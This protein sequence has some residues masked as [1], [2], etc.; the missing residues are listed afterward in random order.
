MLRLS[1]NAPVTVDLGGGASVTLA[2][3][4]PRILAAGRQASRQALM[5]NA[6]LSGSLAMVAFSEGVLCEAITGW[7]GIGDET[8]EELAC[9]PE[10]VALALCDVAFFDRLDA[11]YVIPMIERESEK[12]ASAA[13]SDGTSE[14]ATAG[15]TTAGSAAATAKAGRKTRAKTGNSAKSSPKKAPRPQAAKR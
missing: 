4:T 3:P 8:G 15:K 9:D 12:N 11:A 2:A 10:N 5:D 14:A 1:G 13:S 7:T 6:E